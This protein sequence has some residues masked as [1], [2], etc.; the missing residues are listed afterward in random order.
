MGWEKEAISACSAASAGVTARL[1][2]RQDQGALS[3]GQAWKMAARWHEI[4]EA[5]QKG[6]ESPKQTGGGRA[7]LPACGNDGGI[8][9]RC[10]EIAEGV[11]MVVPGKR[12][13]LVLAATSA[14]A[15]ARG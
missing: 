14:G 5:Q 10:P 2:A 12:M 6:R 11:G 9:R 3:A 1:N 15:T 13:A 8:K 7:V 4:V